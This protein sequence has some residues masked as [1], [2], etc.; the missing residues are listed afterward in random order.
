[1]AAKALL[2]LSLLIICGRSTALPNPGVAGSTPAVENAEG[3][4]PH[5]CRPQV[6]FWFPPIN[7]LKSRS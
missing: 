5:G 7:D 3:P 2:M 6:W 4:G 1:M